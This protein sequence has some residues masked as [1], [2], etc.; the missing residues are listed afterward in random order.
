MAKKFITKDSGKRK[1]YKSGM[2][3]DTQEGKPRFDL[4]IPAGQKYNETLLY[5]WAMLMERGMAKYGERNWEKANSKEEMD[6]FRQSVFRHM[7]QWLGDEED[8]DHVAAI[9]FNIN[10]YEWL[11]EKLENDI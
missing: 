8:E 9:V 5:R 6:R 2:K 7:M 4:L 10:A 1:D 11:K 3:R